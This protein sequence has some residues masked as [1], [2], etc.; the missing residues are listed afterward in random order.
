MPFEKMGRRVV[1]ANITTRF[2]G[3]VRRMPGFDSSWLSYRTPSAE[4][5]PEKSRAA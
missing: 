2:I 1:A 4:T 5:S 3:C